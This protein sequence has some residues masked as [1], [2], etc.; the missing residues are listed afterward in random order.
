MDFPLPQIPEEI[1]DQVQITPQ[2]RVQD[3]TVD[4]IVD[5][6]IPQIQEEIVEVIQLVPPER[7]SERIVEQVVNVPVPQIPTSV[8]CISSA[9]LRL[10]VWRVVHAK[11]NIAFVGILPLLTCEAQLTVLSLT[12]CSAVVVLHAPSAGAASFIEV[13]SW[14]H[15]LQVRCPLMG[16]TA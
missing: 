5:A 4:Q 9:L 3:R 16:E 2:E 11:M 8:A 7:I 13:L 15:S 14:I 12:A 1:A 6:S 10:G